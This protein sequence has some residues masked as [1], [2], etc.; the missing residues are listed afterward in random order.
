MRLTVVG[1]SGAVPGP[2]SAASCYLVEADAPDGRT[3]RLALDMGSGALGALQKY[4]DPRELDGVALSH[5]H[6]DHCAD[7]AGLHVYLK[8][9]PDGPTVVP[10]WGPFGTAG[11]IE[12]LRGSGERS[13]VLEASVWQVGTDVT[14]G[15]MTVRC[16]PV[17]HPVPAYALR[18]EGPSEFEGRTRVVIAYSGDCDVSDGL[19]DAAEGADLFVCEATYVESDQAPRGSHLTAA[20]AGAVAQRARVDTLVLTHVPPWTDPVVVAAEAGTT[21]MGATQMARA[22]L[23]CSV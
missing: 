18:I 3:W 11:R 13:D 17:E 10:V 5:L 19:A 8:H 9:H 12:E 22:G 15:P 7:L 1:C 16:A 21:F 20:A 4:C 23:H 2:A 14:V 6:P